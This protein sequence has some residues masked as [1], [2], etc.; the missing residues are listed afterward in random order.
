[1]LYH[2][3]ACSLVG[4]TRQESMKQLRPALAAETTV[5]I[6]IEELL[7]LVWAG[8]VFVDCWGEPELGG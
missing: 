6:G 3:G 7:L 4:E 8:K 5:V 2:K 1:M